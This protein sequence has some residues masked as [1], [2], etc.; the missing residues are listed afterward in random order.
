MVGWGSGGVLGRLGG[1][2][3]LGLSREITRSEFVIC[4]IYGTLSPGRGL[5]SD[6]QIEDLNVQVDDN[7][8]VNPPVPFLIVT[9]MVALVSVGSYFVN[10]AI[11]YLVAVIASILGGVTALQDQKRRAHPSY[12]TLSWFK[13]SLQGVRYLILAVTIAHVARL[14]ILAAK[15]SGILF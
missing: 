10:S 7:G 11:G 6:W 5:M 12:V 3:A 4:Q 15:G 13:P 14:S 9:V 8:L 1:T 2:S